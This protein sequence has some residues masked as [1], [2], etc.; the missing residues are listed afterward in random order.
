LLSIRACDAETR[1]LPP[2]HCVVH[3]N[4]IGTPHRRPVDSPTRC[5]R[6]IGCDG[7]AETV[8]PVRHRPATEDTVT[9]FQETSYGIAASAE[10][11]ADVAWMRRLAIAWAS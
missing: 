5:A 4:S 3:G 9:L 7:L 10:D 1:I 11:A 6:A 2:N 8:G